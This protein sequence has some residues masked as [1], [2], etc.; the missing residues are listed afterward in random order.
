MENCLINP[1]FSN[2]FTKHLFSENFVQKSLLF[3]GQ[4]TFFEKIYNCL[5][6][7]W[8]IRTIWQKNPRSIVAKTGLKWCHWETVRAMGNTFGKKRMGCSLPTPTVLDHAKINKR[9]FKF[10]ILDVVKGFLVFIAQNN[11]VPQCTFLTT[12]VT[13]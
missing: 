4:N 1:L 8:T 6:I 10:L 3:F 13:S 11:T 7:F 2:V 9:I 5:P 12:I